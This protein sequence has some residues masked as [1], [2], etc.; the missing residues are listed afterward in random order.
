MC[1]NRNS[2]GEKYYQDHSRA[3]H[4][5]SGGSLDIC[6]GDKVHQGS[7]ELHGTNQVGDHG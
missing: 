6:T 3:E 1:I 4:K 2:T 7:K 5:Y